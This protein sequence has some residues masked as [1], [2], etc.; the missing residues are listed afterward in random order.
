MLALACD[1]LRLCSCVLWYGLRC[2]VVF[3]ECQSW[4]LME[5]FIRAKSLPGH[6]HWL[7]GRLCW[8]TLSVLLWT[9]VCVICPVLSVL[10]GWSSRFYCSTPSFWEESGSPCFHTSMSTGLCRYH[11]PDFKLK[12]HWVP[13]QVIL[14]CFSRSKNNGGNYSNSMKIS[15]HLGFLLSVYISL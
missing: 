8:Q 6:W 2:I 11:L 13:T 3:L 4:L 12:A 9:S 1:H 10:Q 7:W 14:N 15:K 5:N